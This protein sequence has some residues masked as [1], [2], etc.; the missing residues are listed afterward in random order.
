MIRVW[1]FLSWA[2]ALSSISLKFQRK[3]SILQYGRPQL[4]SMRCYMQKIQDRAWYLN[5]TGAVLQA[6]VKPGQPVC[7]PLMLF[8]SS[9][10]LDYIKISL[11]EKEMPSQTQSKLGQFHLSITCGWVT[12][13][14]MT[15]SAAH[16][17][18]R[19]ETPWKWS[20]WAQHPGGNPKLFFQ[21]C[22]NN[23]ASF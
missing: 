9:V 22:T 5:S 15:A 3:D 13:C 17:S 6:V 2:E 1:E 10:S 14:S 21:C 7:H 23:R 11:Y 8:Q 4:W 18:S 12:G 16:H 20:G 19:A